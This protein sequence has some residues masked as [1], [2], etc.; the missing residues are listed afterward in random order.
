MR[1]G[2]APLRAHTT[3]EEC[4]S[5][6]DRLTAHHDYEHWTSVLEGAARR[7]G[8]A[9]R[10]LLDVA[11]GTGKSFLPMLDRGYRVAACDVSRAMLSRAAAKCRGR[12]ALH[13][14]DMRRL[15]RLGEHDLVTCLDE[16]INYLLGEQDVRQ[17]FRSAA[18]CLARNGVYLFDLNTLH[19]YRSIFARDECYEQEG[20]LFV[21]RGQGDREAEPGGESS[22]LIEAFAPG[23]DGKWR[24]MSSRHVQR[25]YTHELVVDGL[26]SAGLA[27][28]AVYGQHPDGTLDDEVDEASHTKRIYIARRNT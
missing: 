5:F 19:T 3:F 23:P 12:A 8:L 1:H 7:N 24:R 26:E 17:T 25:H 21:W 22:V 2:Q 20:W 9:G 15:P 16:P 18:G 10:R 11:C 28:V 6:Y 14:A 4:A 27:C 13:L